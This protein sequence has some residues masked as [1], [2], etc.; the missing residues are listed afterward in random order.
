M[1][2]IWEDLVVPING[3]V[4]IPWSELAKGGIHQFPGD[5][6]SYLR[7]DGQSLL[8]WIYTVIVLVVHIPTV[9]IRVVK[10]ETVQTW[11][12]ACTFFTVVVYVQAYISTRLTPETIFVW[13]PLLLLIDAG[14]M[15]Q[16][17]FLVSD[18]HHLLF[19]ARCLWIRMKHKIFPSDPVM[20]KEGILASYLSCT[21]YR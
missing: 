4:S 9:I 6:R 3:T 21:R 17:F 10:W 5:P 14:S 13:T 12:L 20:T 1:A 2:D 8:P 11:C 18:E 19:R 15:S 7:S 16:I